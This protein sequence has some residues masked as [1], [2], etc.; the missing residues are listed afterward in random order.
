MGI[1]QS[2]SPHHDEQ[3]QDQQDDREHVDQQ[4]LQHDH[5]P[6]REAEAREGVGRG[7]RYRQP[8]DDGTQCDDQAMAHVGQERRLPQK[9]GVVVE[10]HP[11]GETDTPDRAICADGVSD[12][13]TSH[14]KGP[15]ATRTI[16]KTGRSVV[17]MRR[18]SVGFV[19]LSTSRIVR[20]CRR[21]RQLPSSMVKV[22]AIAVP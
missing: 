16:R 20:G 7:D 2:H 15:I 21:R 22:T 5:T 4:E 3:R 14:A 18:S 12:V 9:P 10:P 17:R 6:S 8:Q 11:A 1:E 13:S 19:H